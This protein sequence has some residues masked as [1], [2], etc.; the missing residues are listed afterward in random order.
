MPIYVYENPEKE[1]VE[2]IRSLSEFDVGPTEE[3]CKGKKGPWSRVI[4]KGIQK[5]LSAKFGWGKGF[6]NSQTPNK[7]I[8]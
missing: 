7:R 8:P 4:G 1:Q 6:H 3:E 5:R 2:V